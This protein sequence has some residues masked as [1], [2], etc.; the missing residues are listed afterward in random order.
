MKKSYETPT[1]WKENRFT[2]KKDLMVI[3]LS[4]A[5]GAALNE[6]EETIFSIMDGTADYGTDQGITGFSGPSAKERK[7]EEWG[8]LW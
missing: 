4:N 8:R 5:E 3:T 6:E 2:I 1:I 7:E